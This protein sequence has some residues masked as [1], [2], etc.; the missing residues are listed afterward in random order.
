MHWQTLFFSA[1]GRIGRKAFWTAALVLFVAWILSHLLHIFAPLI[2]LVLI[3][4]WVCVYAKRLHDFGRS[5]VLI[6]LP[7]VV[8]FIALTAAVVFGGL[9]V[10]GLLITGAMHGIDP[11]GWA[12]MFGGLGVMAVCLAIAGLAK[13]LFLLWVGLTPGDPSANSYGPAPGPLPPPSPTPAPI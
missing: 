11:S 5:A 7:F 1:E 12:V 13:V 10:I 4:V 2:W 8:I 9:S 3:Y 6:L